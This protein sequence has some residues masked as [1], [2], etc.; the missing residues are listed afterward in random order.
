MDDQGAASSLLAKQRTQFFGKYRGL[1]VDN[2]DDLKRG[3]LQVQVPQVL[4]LQ[5]VWALPC[6]NYAGK[7]V[8]FFAMPPIGTVV[9]VEFEAGEPSFPIWTGCVWALGDIDDAD[10]VPTVKFIKTD[11]FT[12]RIDD[13]GGELRIEDQNGTQIVISPSN[14]LLKS[15]TTKVQGGGGS[16]E[17]ALDN[18]SVTVNQTSMEVK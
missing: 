13:D 1:V 4:G 12:I 14:L 8:G 18:T 9:W 2:A 15:S 11:K 10:A 7:N 17:V 5:P 6:V 3:R 16:K